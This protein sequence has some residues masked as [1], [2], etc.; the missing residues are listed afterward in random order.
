MRGEERVHLSGRVALK[1]RRDVAVKPHG[2]VEPTV[3]K[4]LYRYARMYALR[5]K[6]ASRSVP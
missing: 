1:G 2:H 6:K 4:D 5:Q 3:A